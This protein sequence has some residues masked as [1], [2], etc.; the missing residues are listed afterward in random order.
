MRVQTRI[1]VLMWRWRIRDGSCI[2]SAISWILWKRRQMSLQRWLLL[3]NL[4]SWGNRE[5][6]G[7]VWGW[8]WLSLAVLSL[9]I[10]DAPSGDF[11]QAAGK[12]SQYNPEAEPGAWKGEASRSSQ[13]TATK[14]Q[15]KS[16]PGR[17]VT[18]CSGFYVCTHRLCDGPRRY[19][20]AV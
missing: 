6:G 11:H 3:A 9:R 19:W 14:A 2:S 15:G 13:E 8:N 10:G 7:V 20:R 4:V 17:R 5:S 1:V 16:D 18:V 12:G